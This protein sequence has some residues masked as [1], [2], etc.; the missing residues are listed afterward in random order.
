MENINA[1]TILD[2]VEYTPE[3]YMDLMAN[4][5]LEWSS[6][7]TNVN[8]LGIQRY[9]ESYPKSALDAKDMTGIL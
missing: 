5:V 4:G 3:D 9:L 2:E 7:V 1:Q 8:T 6:H